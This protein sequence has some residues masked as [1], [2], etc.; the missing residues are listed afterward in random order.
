MNKFFKNTL[1]ILYFSVAQQV[2]SQSTNYISGS[3]TDKN[4]DPLIGANINLKGTFMG[5]TTDFNG[6]YR[7]MITGEEII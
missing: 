6:K 2:L 5:S 3:V 1:L 7:A 4:N